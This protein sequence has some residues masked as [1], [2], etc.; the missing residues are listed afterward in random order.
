MLNPKHGGRYLVASEDGALYALIS[1][2]AALAR[3][4]KR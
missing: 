3:S 1:T 2:K 4:A